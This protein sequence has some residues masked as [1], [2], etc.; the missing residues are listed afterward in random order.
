MGLLVGYKLRSHLSLLAG[1]YDGK[2]IGS[3]VPMHRAKS[4]PG[5]HTPT[6]S[7]MDRKISD[8]DRLMAFE[9]RKTMSDSFGPGQ[10]TSSACCMAS[11]SGKYFQ[12][13]FF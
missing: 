8:G 5:N 6:K 7:K 1:A 12:E 9:S 13:L 3:P 4:V 10:G 11:D 2:R